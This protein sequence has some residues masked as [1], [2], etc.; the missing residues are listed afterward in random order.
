LISRLGRK[1]RE[2]RAQT[3]PDHPFAIEACEYLTDGAFAL[4]RVSGAGDVAPVSLV[5]QGDGPQAFD[6]LPQPDAGAS[7][8]FWH[9]AFAL[10]TEVIE[11]GARV[12][13]HD[14]GLYLADLLIPG[15]PEPPKPAEPAEPAI[16][17]EAE[18]AAERLAAARERIAADK[19]AASARPAETTDVGDD[20]RARKLVEAWSEAATLREKLNDREEELAEALQ[21]LLEARKD[22]QPLRDR[23]E[24]LTADVEALREELELAHK[25][26][27]EAR[28][29][30]T[31]KSAELDAVRAELTAA[32]ER[33]V[34]E[35]ELAG[36]P[37][38]VE[39]LEHELATARAETA[40][41]EEKRTKLEESNKSRRNGIARRSEDRAARKQ[42]AE[43]EAELAK[44]EQR[45][46]QLEKDAESFA[47]R[48]EEAVSDS[49]RERI[50]ELEQ[51]VRQRAS[52][53]DDLRALLESERQIVATGR[54]EVEDLKQQLATAAPEQ[55]AEQPRPAPKP[56]VAARASANG[57][58]SPPWSALDEELLARIE[59]AKAL[60]R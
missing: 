50:A 30:A 11:P 24:Q 37:A 18:D 16:T 20:A 5:T 2:R 33:V 29:R 28:M 45:I 9:I 3:Q 51:D 46:Q 38:E 26:G 59:K 34:D 12:W 27:R 14:G 42:V 58:Q 1:R 32:Q 39:R 8:G 36:L 21:E 6:P 10:P 31:E 57:G 49:L 23:V 22:V 4:L 35:Q 17:P 54:R 55:A 19:A 15:P 41:S 53:N 47:E 60:T 7:N 13:L 44:R 40:A 43:L 48:R 56:V 52:T 25:H